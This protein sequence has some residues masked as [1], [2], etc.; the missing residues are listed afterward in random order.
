MHLASRT[1]TFALYQSG[2]LPDVECSSV[3][4]SRSLIPVIRRLKVNMERDRLSSAVRESAILGG[5]GQ[6]LE[7]KR[8]IVIEDERVRLAICPNVRKLAYLF[9]RKQT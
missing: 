6:W 4:V 2:V 9:E 5:L 3:K 1:S 7:N 8:R